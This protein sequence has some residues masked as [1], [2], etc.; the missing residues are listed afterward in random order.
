MLKPPAI[1]AILLSEAPLST[2]LL[3][4]ILLF[5]GCWKTEL[6]PLEL[7]QTRFDPAVGAPDGWVVQSIT[8]PLECPDN[9]RLRF[10][11]IYPETAIS[12]PDT[13]LI[14]SLPA[15]LPTAIIFHGGSFDY[16]LNPSPENPLTGVHLQD[17]SQL[18]AEWAIQKIFVTLGMHPNNNDEEVH[19]GAMA[20]ALAE[21]GIAIIMPMNCWGDLWHNKSAQADN[22]FEIDKFWRNGRVSAEWAYRTATDVQFRNDY[23][24][25]LPFEPK[26]DEV[27]LIGLGEGGRAVTELLSVDNNF[28]DVYDYNPTG[29][30]LDSTA[31]DLNVYYATPELYGEVLEG[32]MRIFPDVTIIPDGSL[33]GSAQLPPRIMYAYSA[34]DS[35]LPT[36]VHNEAIQRLE[37]TPGTWVWETQEPGHIFLN[38]QIGPARS[39]V[40]YL[41]TGA[42]SQPAEDSAD[43]GQ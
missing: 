1:V 42:I 25:Q 35:I 4:I 6:V 3:A 14:P 37:N 39:A 2:R 36:G 18:T 7:A 34:M 40:R 16:V 21:Q 41:L 31:D 19:N 32:L 20:A 10:Y 13:A 12:E 8:M 23:N 30:V 38:N 17:P 28:N 11:L 33:A 9:E 24:I 5:S 26:T 15:P 22:R 29:I 43:T 27:Y